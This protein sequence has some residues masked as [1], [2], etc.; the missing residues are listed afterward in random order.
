MAGC[1]AEHWLLKSVQIDY[2]NVNKV[3]KAVIVPLGLCD[4]SRCTCTSVV[5]VEREFGF[6]F[7]TFELD[8]QTCYF[9][10]HVF[11]VIELDWPLVLYEAVLIVRAACLKVKKILRF[12]NSLLV[13]FV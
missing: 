11:W 6:L 2:R 9:Y 3:D 7:H 10:I 8:L 5:L 13:R 12:G 4:C 1:L